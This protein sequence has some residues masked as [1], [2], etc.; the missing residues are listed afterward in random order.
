M[1]DLLSPL[2]RTERFLA[3]R[4]R[5]LERQLPSDGKDHPVWEEYR[6]TAHAYA[7]V[8]ADL[9]RPDPIE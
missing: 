4:L 9:A 8:R 3:V 1:S 7:L 2:R 6:K 5:E